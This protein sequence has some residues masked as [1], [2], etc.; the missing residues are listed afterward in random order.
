MRF[1]C[2]LQDLERSDGAVLKK[3]AAAR[4]KIEAAAGDAAEAEEELV[5]DDSVV[6]ALT[7]TWRWLC[8][9]FMI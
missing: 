8:V 2:E 6:S 3:V 1:I 9:Q 7:T 4:E 5:R